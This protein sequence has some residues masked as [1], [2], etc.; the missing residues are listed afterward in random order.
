MTS[1]SFYTGE[2]SGNA[3]CS[4]NVH[5]MVVKEGISYDPHELLSSVKGKIGPTGPE[6]LANL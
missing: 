3:R 5:R 2:S 6:D 1:S 4:F